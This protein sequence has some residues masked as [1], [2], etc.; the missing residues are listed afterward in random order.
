[1]GQQ[2]FTTGNG[3]TGNGPPTDD[4]QTEQRW[5]RQRR[6][7]FERLLGVVARMR[8]GSD[9]VSP[10]R[11]FTHTP[12]RKAKEQQRKRNKMAKASRKRNRR[13]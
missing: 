4:G 8:Y 2:Q 5:A 10:H 9:H 13:R 3:P 12:H 7:I 1:M 6:N 11:A